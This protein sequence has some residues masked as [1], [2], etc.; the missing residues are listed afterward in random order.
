MS[1]TA[2][3]YGGTSGPVPLSPHD[4]TMSERAMLLRRAGLRA[5]LRAG[6]VPAGTVPDQADAIGPQSAD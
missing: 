4:P 5:G 1:E 6:S 3:E 2:S